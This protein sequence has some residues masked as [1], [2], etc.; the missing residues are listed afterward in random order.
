MLY[1]KLLTAKWFPVSVGEPSQ[2][3]TPVKLGQELVKTLFDVRGIECAWFWAGLLAQREEPFKG[4]IGI[5]NGVVI[6]PR[7][8]NS[9][10]TIRDVLFIGSA[11]TWVP[12][13]TGAAVVDAPQVKADNVVS[14]KRKW[15]EVVFRIIK[16]EMDSRSTWST[17]IQ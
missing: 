10:Q 1:V 13:A 16:K 14:I 17:W 7:S 15:H 5:R 8:G 3:R 11:M 4:F 9:L 6:V 2:R 12:H